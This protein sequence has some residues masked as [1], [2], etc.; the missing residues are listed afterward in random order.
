MAGKPTVVGI[1]HEFGAYLIGRDI[2]A[3]IRQ[4]HFRGA[5][6]TWPKALDFSGVEQAAESCLDEFL[7]KLARH[8][9]IEPVRGIELRGCSRPVRQAVQYVMSL[10]ENP[11]P[12][13]TAEIAERILRRSGGRPAPR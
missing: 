2:G 4:R 3:R 10:V 7:G 9:G 12:Q 13:P 11:P 6:E 1:K 8:T 5:P